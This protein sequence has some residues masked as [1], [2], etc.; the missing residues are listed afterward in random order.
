MITATKQP[1]P[2]RITLTLEDS[3][4]DQTTAVRRLRSILKRLLRTHGYRCVSVVPTHT[5]GVQNA[6][7]A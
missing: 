3:D 1:A 4:R 2:T 7:V 5:K 6:D